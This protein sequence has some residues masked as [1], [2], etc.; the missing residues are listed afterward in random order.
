VR[1]FAYAAQTMN[2][3]LDSRIGRRRRALFGLLAVLAFAAAILV[4][5]QFAAKRAINA[6]HARLSNVAR[7][8]SSSFQRQVDKFRLVAT[9]LSADSDVAQLLDARTPNATTRL[10]ER[11]ASLSTTLDASVIYLLDDQGTTIASSN[12]R[13]ADSF[14]NENYR[15]RAYFKEAL[16]RGEW[17]QYALGTRSRI[18]GLFVARRVITAGKSIGVIVVKIR[19]DGLERE[20]ASSAGSAFVTSKQGVI[21]VS[22]NPAWRFQTIRKLDDAE[23]SQLRAQ[24]EFGRAPLRQ[25]DLFARAMVIN[26]ASAFGPASKMIVAQEN[27][28]NGWAVYVLAPLDQAV[29]SARTVGRL[30]VML[31]AGTLAALAVFSVVRRRA[32]IMNEQREHDLRIADLKD[33]LVQ[34]NKLSSLGQMAAGIG[35]EINQPLTAISIRAQN[36]FKLI[37]VGRVSEAAA[38]IDEICALTTR[39]GA[40]TGELRRFARR[41]DG[42]VG[43]VSIQEVLDGT[44]ML[45]GDR[46]R[47]T[48][49]VLVIDSADIHV[50][51]DRGKLEQVFVNLIQN[52]IDAMSSN[53]RIDIA[54][55]GSGSTV[56]IMVRD[57]GPGISAEAS[58]RLFQ[59]F[60]TSKEG[61]L[62]LGLVICR[63][64]VADFGGEL[65]LAPSN[66]GAAFRLMLKRAA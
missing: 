27:L 66:S 40:I 39:M 15:F 16:S 32:I 45:L 35:H 2:R 42:H 30:L 37:E 18:P 24:V 51:G 55:D 28:P 7:L 9:T 56:T 50:V 6:E 19:F 63:D 25:N 26:K 52:A 22:S 62:G 21:L 53:G 49:T 29:R 59:P 8:T 23:Q 46:I 38:A 57:D 47:T 13:Q 17:E 44:Q 14:L 34:A 43:K 65:H 31:G 54:I 58:E 48:G 5:D 36:A 60:T 64:I 10:N 61:G 20:W 3:L 33:R 41:A 12:W 1:N 11:L 4:S